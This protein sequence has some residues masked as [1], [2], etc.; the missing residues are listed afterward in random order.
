MSFFIATRLRSIV[1]SP[2]FLPVEILHGLSVLGGKLSVGSP[3]AG[4]IHVYSQV[5]LRAIAR[6]PTRRR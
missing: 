2:F 4:L 5:L 1:F 6:D 3:D